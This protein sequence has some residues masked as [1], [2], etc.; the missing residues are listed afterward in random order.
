MTTESQPRLERLLSRVRDQ[1]PDTALELEEI[2]TGLQPADLT[3]TDLIDIAEQSFSGLLA[4][5]NHLQ[6]SASRILTSSAFLTAAAAAIYREALLLLKATNVPVFWPTLWFFGYILCVTFGALFFL[7]GLWNPRWRRANHHTAPAGNGL[8]KPPPTFTHSFIFFRDV[9]NEIKSRASMGAPSVYRSELL[10]AYLR[11]REEVVTEG[12]QVTLLMQWGGVLLGAAFFFFLA[13][14]STLFLKHDPAST[15]GAWAPVM[16]AWS[17]YFTTLGIGAYIR[18]NHQF[19]HV[20]WLWP[21]AALL[22]AAA[23]TVCLVI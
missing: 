7:A 14:A 10:E 6:D 19:N 18:G 5:K 15:P 8:N 11:E 13:L 20:H 12:K 2:L 1:D 4:T 17:A 21:L 23:G 9:K 3:E 22:M 16:F